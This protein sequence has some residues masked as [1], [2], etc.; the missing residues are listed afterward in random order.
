M[1]TKSRT[2]SAK[3]AKAAAASIS[4]V[5][6]VVRCL[7]GESVETHQQALAELM[8]ELEAKTPLEIYLCENILETLMWIR[9][10]REQKHAMVLKAMASYMV[11][12]LECK[13][14]AAF[15]HRDMGPDRHGFFGLLASN[16]EHQLIQNLL[17]DAKLTLD[18]VRAQA[19]EAHAEGL[20]G[21]DEKISGELRIL[22]GFQTAYER[23]KN[24][25]LKH[26]LLRLQVENLA[27]DQKAI[28][29]GES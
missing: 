25:K 1:T 27:R 6:G 2:S 11:S 22:Q 7:P 20:L 29:H 5:L 17:S 4:G 18:E 13:P 15:L 8:Q 3:P 16:P 28:P 19:I 24:A 10:Y 9:R 21:L 26:D 14:K 12:Y 23:Q